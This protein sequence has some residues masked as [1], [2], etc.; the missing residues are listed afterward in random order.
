MAKACQWRV[1][2]FGP[3]GALN[4]DRVHEW[5]RRFAPVVLRRAESILGNPADA[6]DIA[7]DVFVTALAK[8]DALERNGA[9]LSWF[10]TVTTNRALNRLRTTQTRRRLLSQFGSEPASGPAQETAHSLRALL[11]SLPPRLAELAVYYYIDEMEQRE[12]APLLGCSR[13]TVSRRLG[14]IREHLEEAGWI[15]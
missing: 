9:T 13:R 1:T 3:V 7:Q 10:Y 5:Y 12:I 14:R 6:E 11:L 15:A 8:R 2:P 4:T